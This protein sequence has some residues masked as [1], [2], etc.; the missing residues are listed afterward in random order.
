MLLATTLVLL[1]A[2]TAAVLLTPTPFDPS[3]PLD[4]YILWRLRLPRVL[5]GALIGGLL[6]LA[7]TAYQGCFRNELADPYVI[8]ASTG[9]AL[10]ATL[11]ILSG[12]PAWLGIGGTTLGSFAGALATVA[13]VGAVARAAGTT[14][15]GTLLL[16]G[17]AV[18]S[19]VGGAVSVLAVASRET[20]LAVYVWV[21][22]SLNG[23]GWPEVVLLAPL[24]AATGVA[25][26]RAGRVLDVMSLGEDTAQTMG[27]PV[28]RWRWALLA[29]GSLATAGA[30]AVAGV[31]GF[32]GLIG[33]HL[34]R[35]LVGSSHPKLLPVAAACGAAL[36][37]V[38]DAASHVLG[39][40]LGALTAILGGPLFL[41]LLVRR[42][43]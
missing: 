30:V 32:V 9:A 29:V 23:L 4:R 37:V 1:A 2:A 21:L 42:G 41:V 3:D 15:G 28:A 26:A 10:G 25:L 24:A 19:A 17:V 20:V 14:S 13:V 40:Q 33:P 22:G 36:V 6:S 12:T 35:R 7:G 16:A 38:A 11:A 8:G 18:S 27:V 39:L 31:I 43:R 5:L 34:G